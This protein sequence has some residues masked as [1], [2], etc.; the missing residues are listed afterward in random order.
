MRDSVASF[1]W[2]AVDLLEDDEDDDVDDEDKLAAAEA[3]VEETDLLDDENRGREI[4]ESRLAFWRSS[5][6]ETSQ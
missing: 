6:A 4:I 1:C 2:T 3:G 5:Y